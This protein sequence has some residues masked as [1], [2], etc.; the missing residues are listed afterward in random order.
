MKTQLSSLTKWLAF[1][2]VLISVV[3]ACQK[4]SPLDGIDVVV[5]SNTY[6]SPMAIQFEDGS[7]TA[8]KLPEGITVSISGP[9]KDLVLNDLGEKTYT[10]SGNILTLVLSE[11]ANP[12]E[13]TPVEFTITAAATGYLTASKKIVV[14]DPTTPQVYSMKLTSVTAPPKGTNVVSN[15]LSLT[16]GQTLEVPATTDKP[17]V[18]KITIAPGTQVKDASG[19]IIN[20][21]TVKAQVIQYGVSND[22]S[23]QSFPGGFSPSNVTLKDGTTASG[24]FV[25]A[26]FVA[27]DMEAGGKKVKSFTKPI[28]VQVGIS[29]TAV[30]PE[31]QQA[32]KEND[33]VPTWSYDSETDKW[34]EE[35][36]ATI[37][38][39]TDGKL[40]A[41]FQASHLSY[42]N[43][44]YYYW[45]QRSCRPF[46]PVKISSNVTA[47]SYNYWDYYAIYYRVYPGGYKSYAGYS[48]GVPVANGSTFYYA[49]SRFYSYYPY[50]NYYYYY[51][52]GYVA[53]NAQIQIDIF[54]YRTRTKIGS[55]SVFTPCNT[56]QIPITVNVPNPP[57]YVSVD[58]DFTAKC[59]SKNVTV[60]PST[61]L[62]FYEKLPGSNWWSKWSYAYMVNGKAN[63]TLVDG[64][65]YFVYTYY[66]G[67]A[68]WNQAVFGK[69]K[70]GAM[71]GNSTSGT[72]AVLSGNTT[73]D[74]ATGKVKL[75][76]NYTLKTCN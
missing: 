58:I 65:E 16:A 56:S 9:S 14:T 54:S 66:G 44:D 62:Y 22:E 47:T 31:T 48:Y 10:V 73:Y 28:D 69:N 74:A 29:T 15:T 5:N 17:E 37:T 18:A 19:A 36:V 12:S 34:T 20:A 39:G 27:V 45:G 11:T 61:W 49:G 46:I 70:S 75:T 24:E 51:Y 67:N 6:K 8:T 64:A 76:A 41:K 40:Y 52:K 38:K 32:Y 50:A 42:W 1:A 55:S 59:S 26:G 35:G 30:N 43:C 25:S 21:T 7:S 68:Y 63:I 57:T 23:M 71:A 4:L 60:K 33:T 3:F 53:A 2:V 13:T 72:G